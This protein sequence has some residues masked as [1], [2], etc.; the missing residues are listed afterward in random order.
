MNEQGRSF[1]E[2]TRDVRRLLV[3][4][5]GFLG[6]TV[7]LFPALRE[8]R[9][10][11]PEAELHVMAAEHVKHI[12][13]VV[14]GVDQIL[15]YPRFPKGPRW[16]EDFGRVGELRRSK[17]DVVINL[18]GSDRSSILTAASGA[19]WRLGRVPPKP[20]AFWKYCFSHTVDITHGGRPVFEQRWECIRAA[21]I[22]VGESAKFDLMIPAD[23]Q[24][25][26]NA[27]LGEARPF[28]HVSPCT[29]QDQKELP[30][31]ELTSLVS[32]LIADP[33]GPAVAISC[34][35]N[36]RERGKLRTLLAGLPTAP[37]RVFEGNLT[38]LELSAV[39]GRSQAHFGGDSGALH[40]ALMMGTPTISWFRDYMGKAEWLPP[41]EMH[42]H[43]IGEESPDGL[44]GVTSADLLAAWKRL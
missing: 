1:F 24:E 34:A 33:D 5:L 4:D 30:L 43:V 37:W 35:P 13:Q 21:G 9:N 12:L 40:L 2:C 32:E 14:P 41:G 20:A 38:L 31:S 28:I 10:A 16:Y 42:R 29:T 25:S 26:V 11:Y 6:D 8:I 15:G 22:P 39:I 44:R 3:L 19:K 7:H 36:D 17:Y 23:V 18:N 27:K